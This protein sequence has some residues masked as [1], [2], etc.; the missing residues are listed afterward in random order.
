MRRSGW[1]ASTV[2]ESGR[3]QTCQDA[4]EGGLAAAIGADEADALPLADRETDVLKDGLDAVGFVEVMSGK[5]KSPVI[6]VN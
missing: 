5:H 3:S 2:P 4:Q 1:V 6:R